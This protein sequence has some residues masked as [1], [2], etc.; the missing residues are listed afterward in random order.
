MGYFIFSRY[1]PGDT[2]VCFRNTRLKLCA[3]LKPHIF[4]IS[5]TVSFVA[6][7]AAGAR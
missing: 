6:A 1:W 5:A 3:E 7:T 4:P 2:P